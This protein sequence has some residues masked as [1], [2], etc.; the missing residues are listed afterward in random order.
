M[1]RCQHRQR[2]LRPLL[3]VV[4]AVHVSEER[5]Q[6]LYPAG[7]IEP[8]TFRRVIYRHLGRARPEV[9]VGPAAGVDVAVV[10]LGGGRV[11]ASTTDPVFV[12]PQYGWRRA[13]WF[14]I[15]ILASDA[16]MSALAPAYLSIDLNLPRSLS[17]R[18]LEVLWH[19]MHAA[20]DDL[21]I[22]VISG[23]TARYDGCDYPMVGGATVL[24]VGDADRYV[25][26]GMAR[27]GDVLLCSKGAAIE[28]AALMAA[29][30]PTAL[31]DRL[32]SDV[33]A[34][35]DALFERMTVVEDAAVA[36]S[37]GVRDDGV[38]ALH[39]ATEGGVLGGVYEMASASGIGVVLRDAAVIVRPEVRAICRLTGM[40]PLAAISEGTLLAAVRPDRA[41]AVLDAWRRA[42]IEGS[43][44]G[45]F[46][47][48]E[49]GLTRWT[50]RGEAPLHHPG[51][52]PFW[53]AFA[54]ALEAWR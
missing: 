22:A 5:S 52:D 30:F 36:V 15:H 17:D 35:A 26:S 25:T 1:G 21:G 31:A 43:A 47:A 7:K 27:V 46:V 53:Q 8:E 44:I 37:V 48:P 23:H 39:D 29:T 11:L 16:A 20:C 45:E 24:A 42:G 50:E 12:V 54:K 6:T 2:P 49:R 40:D 38:T 28:A 4:G 33:V 32:G 13:A 18:D 34:R 9:R 3:Q 14:A 19:A 41:Q 10:D 51:V